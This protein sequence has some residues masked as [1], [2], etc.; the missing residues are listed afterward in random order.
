MRVDGKEREPW[1]NVV[2]RILAE[3]SFLCCP[4]QP[5]QL[6]PSR[7]FL[8]ELLPE[9]PSSKRQKFLLGVLR[10]LFC[11]VLS[12]HLRAVRFPIIW[13]FSFTWKLP[14]IWQHRLLSHLE[15]SGGHPSME[16]M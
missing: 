9:L 5:S 15:L 2:A 3:C 14:E 1:G 8:Q 16:G 6:T 11:F 10:F 12:S 4:V 13:A 7:R